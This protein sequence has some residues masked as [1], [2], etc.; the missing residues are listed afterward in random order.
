MKKIIIV[1]LISL[2]AMSCKKN[3]S[4][5]NIQ[6]SPQTV[7]CSKS[8]AFSFAMK[9]LENSIDM[10]ITGKKNLS[11]SNETCEYKFLFEGISSSKNH[12]VDFE[13]TVKKNENG[14]EV[15]SSN[16]EKM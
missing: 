7:S 10:E 16:V 2:L 1:S 8:E 15:I 6:D 4:Y 14:W 11:S 13:I 12:C 5:S 3:E 9:N